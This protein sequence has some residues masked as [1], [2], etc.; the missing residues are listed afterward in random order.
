MKVKKKN[1]GL[2]MGIM[3]CTST[4]VQAQVSK[5]DV[6]TIL[7]NPVDRRPIT[8]EY[9]K[10]Q[11]E[12]I[13][14]DVKVTDV[15]Y[16]DFYI[17]EN[18]YLPGNA[19]S[20]RNQF[21][22]IV[23]SNNRLDATVI[24]NTASYLNGGLTASRMPSTY[25]YKEGVIYRIEKLLNENSLP[26]FYVNV[27]I[28]R[29]KPDTRGF[30]WGQDTWIDAYEKFVLGQNK[31]TRFDEAIFQYSHLTIKSKYE[32]L[33]DKE[34][35]FVNHFYVNYI[36]N[37]PEKLKYNGKPLALVYEKMFQDAE[38]MINTLVGMTEK[39][40][41]LEVVISV[42]DCS[43]PKVIE[44]SLYSSK[45]EY[46]TTYEIINRIKATN[47]LDSKSV[48]MIYG[49]DDVIQS[50]VA[51]DYTKRT[52]K[53]TEYVIRYLQGD[54]TKSHIGPYDAVSVEEIITSEI[55]FLNEHGT[56]VDKVYNVFV[57][58]SDKQE[59][60]LG[61]DQAGFVA[62]EIK[63]TPN[64]IVLDL[65]TNKSD[66]ELMKALQSYGF[67]MKV[68]SGWNTIG[69]AINLGLA[70]AQVQDKEAVGHDKLFAQHI[71]ED[72]IY[73]NH[74]KGVLDAA[75]LSQTFTT[76]DLGLPYSITSAFRPY[77]RTF[78]ISLGLIEK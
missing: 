31:Q 64:A 48:S 65:K 56:Y 40:P 27:N 71:Y 30:Y 23:R 76:M 66:E 75:L 61:V 63:A 21:D 11:A 28:P 34:Q 42:D 68:Y 39:Y 77:N 60:L 57:H 6:N 38:Y 74:Y 45:N 29:T 67:P 9:V 4:M 20:I 2:I 46:S 72:W 70:H 49:Y 53:K 35:L 16:A 32:Q 41:Q 24:L 1:I 54:E 47:V 19:E 50:I 5:G 15:Q 26:N 8:N 7:L 37:C 22:E 36:E 33:T 44:N 14:A 10:L 3:L 18:S 62:R 52:G 51:R 58:N 43:L 55:E 17:G 73:N 12:L 59:N 69:N 78:E 13:G 25:K